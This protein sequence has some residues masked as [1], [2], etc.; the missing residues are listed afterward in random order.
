MADTEFGTNDVQTVKRWAGVLAREAIGETYASRFM[1]RGENNVIQLY[2]KLEK[3]AGD[4]IKHHLKTR[5]TGGGRYGSQR[6]KGF[7]ERMKFPQDNF[8]I[9]QLRHGH[10]F[11]QTS[12]QRVPFELRSESRDSLK[13]WFAEAFDTIIACK[14]AGTTG[15]DDLDIE[16]LDVEFDGNT[17]RAPDTAHR[18]QRGN[19]ASTEETFRT[20][21]VDLAKA[22]AK[23]LRPRIKPVRIEGG[24]YYVM[25]LTSESVYQLQK[26]TGDTEWKMIQ[27]R[28]AEKGSRN[29]IFTGALGIWNGVILWEWDYL[30]KDTTDGA[31][32]CYNLLLG[33]QAG[34]MG[35]G[36]KRTGRR[37]GPQSGQMFSWVEDDDDYGDKMGVGGA[38]MVGVQKSQYDAND[39][40]TKTDYAVI[41]VETKDP[42]IGS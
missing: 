39:D 13:L 33:A 19:G 12:Q 24:R 5:A 42:A 40:G 25:L 2:V 3:G 27:A 7:E 9:N 17:L 11:D 32:T 29:P 35:F 37:L 8:R 16:D 14:L 30:P 41:R 36:G 34:A 15:V 4:E 31:E 18:L 23:T 22:M 38:T 21:H 20:S 26:A 28:A 1:G 10:S 6:L